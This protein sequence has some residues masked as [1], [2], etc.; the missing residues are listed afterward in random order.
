LITPYEKLAEAIVRLGMRNPGRKI[1]VWFVVPRVPYVIC[2]PVRE[3]VVALWERVEEVVSFQFQMTE[4]ESQNIDE[5]H[6]ITGLA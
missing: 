3:C 6:P 5:R 2:D 1:S 4:V